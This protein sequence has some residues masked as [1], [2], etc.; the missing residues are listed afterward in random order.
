M[1]CI[2]KSIVGARTHYLTAKE[3]QNTSTSECWHVTT[4]K[5]PLNL[6]LYRYKT[7]M[8]TSL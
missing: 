1:S 5:K 3:L 8:N 4:A 2:H 6:E 7:N